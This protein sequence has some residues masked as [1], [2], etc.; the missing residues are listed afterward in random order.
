[1]AQACF[2]E[3]YDKR[4]DG[5]EACGFWVVKDHAVETLDRLQASDVGLAPCVL[6]GLNIQ[7][8]P[9]PTHTH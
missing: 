6:N 7:T 9:S 8:P 2:K 4:F 3:L 5:S 1:M